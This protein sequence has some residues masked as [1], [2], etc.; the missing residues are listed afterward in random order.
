MT[1][2]QK[3]HQFS[4][5]L[6]YILERHPEEFGL[7]PDP[8]GYVKIKDLLKA[9]NETDGWRHIRASHINEL[10]LVDAQPPVEIDENRIRAKERSHLPEIAPCP[11]PPK[12]L[13][14]CVR[15]RSYPHVPENGLRPT[16]PPRVVCT[17]EKEM[18]ER[19]GKRKDPNPVLLT[20]HTGKI[21]LGEVTFS[22]FADIFYIA[23]HLPA[24]AVT[25]PP[26]P[27]EPVR[28]KSHEPAHAPKPPTQAGTFFMTP[29]MFGTGGTKKKKG[30]KKKL[31]WKQDRKHNHRKKEN[32]WSDF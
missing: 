11:S 27:K 16:D 25:G 21:A 14:T 8:D 1:P 9:L 20:I 7:I 26:L 10:M 22:R 4:R 28:E 3:V 2:Q 12:L 19:L 6:A 32:G 15:Q 30:K 23:D 29:E 24:E 13:Y 18:A 17:Q 5:M 31:D